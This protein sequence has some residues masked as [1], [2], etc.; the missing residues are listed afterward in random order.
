MLTNLDFS[1]NSKEKEEEKTIQILLWYD[2]AL[3]KSFWRGL[4]LIVIDDSTKE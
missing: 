4:H 1:S 2:S 3:F